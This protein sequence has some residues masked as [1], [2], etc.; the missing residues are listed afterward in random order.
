MAPPTPWATRAAISHSWSVANP[1]SSEA[2]VKMTT[3]M[4][5]IRRRP[6]R[7]P[8][9]PPEEKQP[10][11]GERVGGDDPLEA[12]GREVEL[13]LDRGQGDVHD[14]AVEDHHHLDRADQHQGQP[15]VSVFGQRLFRTILTHQL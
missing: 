12:R 9:R 11:E 13:V 10:A 3:P 6:K 7:S 4:V 8:L 5:N 15:G 14:G 2:A 1:P